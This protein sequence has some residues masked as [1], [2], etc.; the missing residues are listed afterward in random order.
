MTVVGSLVN[1]R[2]GFRGNIRWISAYTIHTL[3]RRTMH[4]Q[5]RYRS[6]K[7]VAFLLSNWSYIGILVSRVWRRRALFRCVREIFLCVDLSV[8]VWNRR[9]GGTT[10]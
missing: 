2:A 8:A 6:F 7:I 1:I 5:I 3:G 10:R 4:C 9:K